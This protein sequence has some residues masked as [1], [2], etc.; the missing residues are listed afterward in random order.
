[1][2]CKILCGIP[3]ITLEGTKED[4]EDIYLRLDKLKSWPSHDLERW[5]EMLKPVLFVA[6][7][8]GEIDRRFWSQIVKKDGYGC[9]TEYISGWIIAFC[10]FKESGTRVTDVPNGT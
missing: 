4:W 1:M 10:P 7:F 5:Y 2:I 6:E 9:G 8:E 3:K